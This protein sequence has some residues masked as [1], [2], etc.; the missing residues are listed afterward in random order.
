MFVSIQSQQVPGT[1]LLL[2]LEH[3]IKLIFNQ[4]SS[5]K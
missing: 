1:L 2:T 3:V 5:Y 4:L